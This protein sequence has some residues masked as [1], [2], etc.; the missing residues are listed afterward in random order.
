MFDVAFVSIQKHRLLLVAPGLGL[1]SQ[2]A[3]IVFFLSNIIGTALSMGLY[4][5]TLAQIGE[6][7][8]ALAR[9]V[10]IASSVCALLFG[11]SFLLSTAVG[12][13]QSTVPSPLPF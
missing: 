3:T 8:P 13:E 1:G 10:G 5:F 4:A 6:R 12:T 9:G 2:A 7:F 11:F